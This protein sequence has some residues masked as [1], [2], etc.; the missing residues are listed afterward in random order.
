MSPTPGGAAAPQ[1]W[2]R[3]SSALA[4]LEEQLLGGQRSL[5]L[6]EL[7]E[8]LGAELEEVRVYWHALGLPT[9]GP[10][11][12]AYTE[13]DVE[14]LRE[15]LGAARRFDLSARTAV[16]LIRSVGHTTDRL[17]LWQVEA[18]V[19]QVSQRHRLDD[20]SARLAV[21]DRLAEVAP[22]LERQ[23]VHA[24]RRQLV[25]MA[26]RF[27]SELVSAGSAHTDDELP[28][29]R[30]VGFAD[31]VGFTRRTAEL[32]P[33]ELAD[34]VQAFEARAR[35]VVTGAGGR[36]VKTIGDAVLFVADDAARGARVALGLAQTFGPGSPTPVRV[37]LVWGRVLSRFGDVFGPSVNL[38]ARLTDVA[39]PGTVLL[40][41]G[42]AALLAQQPW[43]ALDAR[44]E[45]ELAGLGTVTTLRLS[46]RAG[47]PQGPAGR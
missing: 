21:L 4:A 3:A 5:T 25:A 19:E 16:S 18:L 38:A 12:A 28:L 45:R 13:D 22:V 23:L 40:D 2:S 6:A 33:H 36:V 47:A 26:G 31:I 42:T 24:W 7:A 30:A 43:A 35:D 27:A 14:A 1:S 44:T 15:L 39:E 37:G 46:R 17:V 9:A 10:D 41:A 11:V 34:Y 32:G 8:R 20:A 29:A